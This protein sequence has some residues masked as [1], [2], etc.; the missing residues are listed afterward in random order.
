MSIRIVLM[1]E[2]GPPRHIANSIKPFG[3]KLSAI[4]EVRSATNRPNIGMHVVRIQH[5]TAMQSLG[6]LVSALCKRLA[7]EERILV[8]CSS[9]VDVESFAVLAKC[10]IYHSGLCQAGNTKSYNL[11]RWDAGETKVMAC[12][13]AF[14]QCMDRPHVRYVVVFR[15]SYGLII[16]NQMLG[17]AGRD[18]KESHVIFLTDQ[19]GDMC[20]GRSTHECVKEL[21]D[22]LNGK[23]CRRFTNT[24]CMDGDKLAVKCMDDPPGIHCDVCDPDSFMQRLA[25][26]SIEIPLRSPEVPEYACSPIIASGSSL[27]GHNHAPQLMSTST[28]FFPESETHQTNIIVNVSI[29]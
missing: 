5:I 25:V 8:F 12:T 16:N 27:Q 3:M 6:Q 14:S 19:T 4:T 9:Q 20:R 22:L 29:L 26:E 11:H 21:D 10:A 7:E 23:K 2:M 18:E 17:R 24:L 15:P 13:T 1:T 28:V